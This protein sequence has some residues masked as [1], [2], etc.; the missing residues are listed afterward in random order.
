[1]YEQDWVI[2]QIQNMAQMIAKLVFNK[3][4]TEYE[5]NDQ[6]NNTET[7]LLHKR[8][9]ELLSALKINQAEDLLFENLKTDNLDYLMV[10][11]D[12]YA[13]VNEFNDSA[14]VENDFSRDELER[15]LEEIQKMFGIRL[16]SDI[17]R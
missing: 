1:M 16:D 4:S 3:E 12:F 17:T 9:L 5:I 11:V 14:L 6:T 7:D 8:L 10:A 15:G 2:R 13:R